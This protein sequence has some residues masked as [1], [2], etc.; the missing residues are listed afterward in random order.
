MLHSLNEENQLVYDATTRRWQWDMVAL[1]GM[2]ITDNVVELIVGKVSKLPETT[3]AVLKLAAC[4]GNRYELATLSIIARQ[5]KAAVQTDLQ[6]AIGE[7]II[8]PVGSLYKFPHDRIQQAAYS[9]I[10][11]ANIKAFH[12]EIGRLL[13]QSIP[14]QKQEERIFEIV[15]QLNKGQL[16]I[17]HQDERIQLGELNLIA[18]KR[19]KKAQA[20]KDALYFF[21]Q[22][23][24]LLPANRCWQDYYALTLDLYVQ[25]HECLFLTADFEGAEQTFDQIDTYAKRP[26]HISRSQYTLLNQLTMTKQYDAV[27]QKGIIYLA[28]LGVDIIADPR[29]M[30]SKKH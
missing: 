17:K 16:L 22:G 13:L 28:N 12:L 21:Q 7:G 29:W 11:E 25:L 20:Y 3:L 1:Q 23:I 18:G 24:R 8:I 26:E 19:A 15:N 30:M 2:D 9:L 27:V 6:A 4:I 5:T 10:P 14:Q